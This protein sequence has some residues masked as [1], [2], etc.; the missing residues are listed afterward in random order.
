MSKNTKCY[1]VFTGNP[2]K[3]TNF[4]IGKNKVDKDHTDVEPVG[5]YTHSIRIRF[6]N[7]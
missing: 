7:R 5:D 3:K 6:F 2:A 4:T 1:L